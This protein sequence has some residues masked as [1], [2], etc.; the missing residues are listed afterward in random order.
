MVICF[1]EGLTL[2]VQA[3][4]T[5]V[6]CYAQVVATEQWQFRCNLMSR[7]STMSYDHKT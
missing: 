3:W 1:V 5:H 6:Q 7:L 2:F 4:S